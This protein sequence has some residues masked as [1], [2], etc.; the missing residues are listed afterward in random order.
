MIT[1]GIEAIGTRVLIEGKDAYVLL[2][3]E[4]PAGTD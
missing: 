1:E 3:G 4:T 2:D